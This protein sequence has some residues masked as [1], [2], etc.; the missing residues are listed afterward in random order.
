MR[1]NCVAPGPTDTPLL[2]WPWRDEEY[3]ETLPARR[4]VRP[5]EVA[6]AVVFLAEEGDFFCGQVLSPNAAAVI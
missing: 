6:E 4:L 5:E 3:T 1:V 2:T